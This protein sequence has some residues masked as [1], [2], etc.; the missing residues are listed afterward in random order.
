[1]ARAANHRGGGAHHDDGGWLRQE[2]G[3]GMALMGEREVALGMA[4]F[5]LQRLGVSPSTAQATVDV[6]RARMPGEG[7]AGEPAGAA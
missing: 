3:V 7:L 6:L 5:A 4:D 1:M 2:G